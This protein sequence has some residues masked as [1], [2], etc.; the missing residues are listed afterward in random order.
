VWPGFWNV[1]HRVVYRGRLSEAA[2]RDVHA[3]S[4]EVAGIAAFSI[5]HLDQLIARFPERV[6][7]GMTDAYLRY[8]VDRPTV[9]GPSGEG[10]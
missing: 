10:A 5:A 3:P 7:S 4:D 9:R 1:E 2:W 8:V 6:A